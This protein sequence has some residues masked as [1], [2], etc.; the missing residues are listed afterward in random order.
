MGPT[1]SRCAKM[2]QFML[3]KNTKIKRVSFQPLKYTKKCEEWGSNPRALTAGDLKSP[4][5]TT[6]T[7][8]RATKTQVLGIQFFFSFGALALLGFEPRL[9]DS[10][11]QVLN[12][13]DYSANMVFSN[14]HN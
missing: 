5:L 11:S 10:K 8:S 4:S 9:R 6:R 7:S 13:L 3:K 12:Q 1:R 2:L 14:H